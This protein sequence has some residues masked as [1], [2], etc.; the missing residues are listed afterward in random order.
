[1][2]NIRQT[3][4]V[5]P[6]NRPCVFAL[7]VYP[8]PTQDATESHVEYTLE[9]KSPKG[10]T[11]IRSLRYS[12]LREVHKVGGCVACVTHVLRVG[13]PRLVLSPMCCWH[14]TLHFYMGHASFREL[15]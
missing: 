2:A 1:M 5:R 9:V 7:L 12:K 14:T 15:L 10:V 13:A 3:R 4:T 8:C 6:L 11:Y